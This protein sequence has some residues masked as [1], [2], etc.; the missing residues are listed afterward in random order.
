MEVGWGHDNHTGHSSPSKGLG[1]EAARR[2]IETGR[3]HAVRVRARNDDVGMAD[4]GM[5][6]AA[7]RGGRF[8]Q[9]GV[10][11]MHGSQQ[12]RQP[13]DASTCSSRMLTSLAISV[14]GHPSRPDGQRVFETDVFGSVRVLHA[15][16]ATQKHSED[17]VVINAGS[18]LGSIAATIAWAPM[19][20]GTAPFPGSTWVGLATCYQ[21]RDRAPHAP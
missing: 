21:G 8:V 18:G 14:K 12:A 7:E 6:A 1:R 11:S 9:L 5:K 4:L 10:T 13:W 2:F 16:I 20:R 17:P 3:G 19:R 15:F